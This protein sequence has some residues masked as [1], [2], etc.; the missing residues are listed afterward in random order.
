[1]LKTISYWLLDAADAFDDKIVRQQNCDTLIHW[2]FYVLSNKIKFNCPDQSFSQQ[3]DVKIK[4][5]IEAKS[6]PKKEKLF[7]TFYYSICRI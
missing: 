3:N 5:T 4:W 1:M 6:T 7:D 2:M